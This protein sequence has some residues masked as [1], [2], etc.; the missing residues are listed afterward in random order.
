MSSIE[1]IEL[2]PDESMVTE[3]GRTGRIMA[4]SPLLRLWRKGVLT[5]EQYR[6]GQC[7][8][9][10]MGLLMGSRGWAAVNEEME[11]VTSRPHLI[12]GMPGERIEAASR[13]RRSQV[14][15]GFREQFLTLV[16]LLEGFGTDELDRL[17]Q[18]RKGNAKAV[19][20]GALGLIVEAR[21]YETL[22]HQASVWA[23]AAA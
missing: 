20:V 17:W 22:R 15:V 12:R 18:R 19:S 13:V 21:V 23:E 10:D 8:S 4:L 14:A 6:V 2:K 16:G 5:P 3:E 1:T 11:S 9:A 7:L